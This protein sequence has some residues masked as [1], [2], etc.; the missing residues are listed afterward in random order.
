MEYNVPA[1]LV[2]ALDLLLDVICVVDVEGRFIAISAACE[3]VFGY[4]QEELIGTPM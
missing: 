1:Q 3:Q 4:T 2:K